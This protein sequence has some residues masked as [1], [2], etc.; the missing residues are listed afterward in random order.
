MTMMALYAVDSFQASESEAGLASSIF[1][2]G[3]LIARLF[4]GKYVEVIGRKKLL[5]TSLIFFLIGS[6]SYFPVQNLTLLLL[7]RFLHGVAFGF[8]NTALSTICLDAIPTERRGEGTGYFSLS[9]TG[10]TAV[11]PF[12]G[13]IVATHAGYDVMFVVCT[14]FSVIA[15]LICLFTNVKEA[16]LTEKERKRMKQGFRLQDFFEKNALPIS[17]MMIVMG[18]GYSSVI[19][20]LNTY[21]M[22]LNLAHTASLYF[23]VYAVFLFIFRPLAGRLL[24]TKGDNIVMYPAIFIYAASLGLLGIV[25]NGWMMILAGILLALGFGTLMSSGQAIAVKV[26]PR[27]HIGL[28]NSTYYIFLDTGMGIGPFLIG[29]IIPLIGYRNMYLLLAVVVL[30]MITYYYFV[31]GRKTATSQILNIQYTNRIS[32]RD[33]V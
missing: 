26:S 5:Y 12:I 16:K 22:A 30:S 8:L 14:G 31:H 32:K 27:Q 2:I 29:S 23:V 1:I 6:L 20:F 28:A 3:T 13:V 24:D 33:S 11:G 21:A 10:A 4:A 9:S 18:I 19:S 15:A 25:S 7:V 17:L